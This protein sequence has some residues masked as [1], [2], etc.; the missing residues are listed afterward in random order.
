MR[1]QRILSLARK[2]L[3]PKQRPL[4]VRF[5]GD[6]KATIRTLANPEAEVSC[7]A[8]LRAFSYNPRKMSMEEISDFLQA[9]ASQLPT[10]LDPSERIYDDGN[11][12]P[13]TPTAPMERWNRTVDIR[14]YREVRT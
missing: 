5:P 6:G 1:K 10:I 13:T 9:Y 12:D 7:G 14:L 8:N 2:Y 11:P 3:K 4:Y